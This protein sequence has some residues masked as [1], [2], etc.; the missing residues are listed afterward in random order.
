MKTS[1]VHPRTAAKGRA[2]RPLCPDQKADERSDVGAAGGPGLA[3]NDA[4]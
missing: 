1:T 3:R 2:K 4:R